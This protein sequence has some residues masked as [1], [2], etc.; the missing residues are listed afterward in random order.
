MRWKSCLGIPFCG[1]TRQ[2]LRHFSGQV[3]RT[4]RAD[5]RAPRG[6]CHPGDL[7]PLQDRRSPVVNS[8]VTAL[9]QECAGDTA[10][11][12][13]AG[14]RDEDPG[15]SDSL[16][17][18]M[19]EGNV[20]RAP[21]RID[22]AVQTI[23]NNKWQY[24]PVPKNATYSFKSTLPCQPFCGVPFCHAHALAGAYACGAL[25]CGFYLGV[26]QTFRQQATP[27]P[28]GIVPDR[29]GRCKKRK[30]GTKSSADRMRTISRHT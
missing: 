13:A 15:A 22:T 1:L 30:P 5:R 9:N 7:Q 18:K 2:A 23:Y 25:T 17:H 10:G 24:P 16:Q 21:R 3:D 28:S 29:P 6:L 11:R 4:R 12:V 27:S 20:T 26:V 14:T 8:Q 19:P